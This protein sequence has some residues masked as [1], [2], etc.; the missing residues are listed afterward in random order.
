M[1]KTPNGSEFLDDSLKV[2]GV[3]PEWYI[4]YPF[5]VQLQTRG[6]PTRDLAPDIVE[7][8][9]AGIELDWL[10][11]AKLAEQPIPEDRNEQRFWGFPER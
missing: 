6:I 2:D 8:I 7:A 4:I 5:F 3:F 11:I 1:T 9:L 10:A